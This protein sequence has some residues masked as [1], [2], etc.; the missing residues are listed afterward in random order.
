LVTKTTNNPIFNF[1][2]VTIAVLDNIEDFRSL[3]KKQ[4]I[5]E[6]IEIAGAAITISDR[7]SGK[8]CVAFFADKD[9]F[10]DLQYITHEVLHLIFY[11]LS[12]A[13]MQLNEET[14]E[15]FAYLTG[16]YN[17]MIVEFINKKQYK[18]RVG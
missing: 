9:K 10:I 8:Y 11:I 3:L 1:A 6:E 13:G 17:N 5:K 18:I 2:T 16:Y 4:K 15:T 7:D 14:Q 12:D